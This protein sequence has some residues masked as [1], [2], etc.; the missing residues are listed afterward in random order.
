MKLRSRKFCVAELADVNAV[1]MVT[2]L[3][4]HE[5]PHSPLNAIS[6]AFDSTFATQRTFS[7]E[8]IFDRYPHIDN[9]PF[10]PSSSLPPTFS[11]FKFRW[12]KSN[13]KC[14]H[15]EPVNLYKFTNSF[16]Y[17]R[18]IKHFRKCTTEFLRCE[19][20]MAVKISIVVF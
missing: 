18:C 16:F 3:C 15:T 8:L 4:L 6:T 14:L 5:R 7:R 1:S 11:C 12:M 10:W 17:C 13:G 20:L 2:R 9:H 19:V